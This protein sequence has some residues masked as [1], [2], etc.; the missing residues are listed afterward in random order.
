MNERV[1]TIIPLALDALWVTRFWTTTPP[2]YIPHTAWTL[3]VTVDADAPIRLARVDTFAWGSRVEKYARRPSPYDSSGSTYNVSTLD[4]TEIK[5]PQAVLDSPWSALNVDPPLNPV[6]WTLIPVVKDA[7][8][9]SRTHIIAFPRQDTEGLRREYWRIRASLR[10]HLRF[11][12][13]GFDRG[14]HRPH[15][16]DLPRRN[17]NVA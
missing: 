10:R 2:I 6:T 11:Q 16:V 13:E 3:S 7:Q 1:P 4:S 9:S 5:P 17:G 14:T 8:G 15:V 12:S